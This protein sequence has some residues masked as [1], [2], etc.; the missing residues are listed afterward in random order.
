MSKFRKYIFPSSSGSKTLII[1]VISCHLPGGTDENHE[2]LRITG[3]P[4]ESLT[5]HLLN[6]S[7]KHRLST[8]LFCNNL[9]IS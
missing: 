8:N 5:E 4:V 1:E 3:V 7:S 6:R 2:N 9:D